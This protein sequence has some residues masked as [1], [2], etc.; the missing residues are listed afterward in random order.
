MPGLPTLL[1]DGIDAAVDASRVQAHASPVATQTEAALES[2]RVELQNQR[3]RVDEQLKAIEEV[4]KALVGH[5]DKLAALRA[6]TW[7]LPR[8]KSLS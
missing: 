8:K 2:K 3:Q 6:L 5:P 7:H 1:I 4:H